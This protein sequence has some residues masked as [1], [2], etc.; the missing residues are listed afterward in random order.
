MGGDLGR[1][2]IDEMS[3]PVMGN[4]PEFGPIPQGAD[5]RL[6]ACREDPA[7]AKA[8]NVSELTSNGS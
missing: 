3:D 7:Q 4:A 2:V 1:V 6:F 5:R 8:D